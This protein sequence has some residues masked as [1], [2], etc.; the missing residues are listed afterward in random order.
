MQPKEAAP[1]WHGHEAAEREQI[2]DLLAAM[3]GAQQHQAQATHDD[4]EPK[5]E[6]LPTLKKVVPGPQVL[7]DGHGQQLNE[8]ESQQ[9]TAQ[10]DTHPGA[11]REGEP[12]GPE[13]DCDPVGHAA[14]SRFYDWMTP[15]G[16]GLRRKAVNFPRRPL[17]LTKAAAQALPARGCARRKNNDLQI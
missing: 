5:L 3:L 4:E 14:L 16:A 2:A 9:K 12:G 17:S 7:G 11:I 15:E 10:M 1:E 6:V 8:G 13:E